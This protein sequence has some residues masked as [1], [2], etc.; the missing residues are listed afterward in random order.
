[1]VVRKRFYGTGPWSSLLCSFVFQTGLMCLV[2][3]YTRAMLNET[4]TTLNHEGAV[5][6]QVAHL[7]L[8]A[9]EERVLDTNARK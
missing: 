6:R 8:F 2:E 9:I 4:I 1:M 5:F 3:E 7:K